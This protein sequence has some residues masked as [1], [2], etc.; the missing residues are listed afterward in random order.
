M[1]EVK[2]LAIT[3]AILALAY[4]GVIH[5]V[6]GAKNILLFVIWAICLPTG[7]AGMTPSMHKTLAEDDPPQPIARAI[8]RVVRWGMLL[9]LLWTGHLA[10]GTAW[11][12]YM[13]G[14]AV[15]D[16][17]AKKIRAAQA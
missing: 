4:F 11:A 17:Q 13:L 3:L 2:A 12:V 5:G 7:L 14:I 8:S 1:K 6:Q 15:A 10:T 9:L 16:H